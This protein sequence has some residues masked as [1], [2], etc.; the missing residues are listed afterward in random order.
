MPKRKTLGWLGFA[1]AGYWL[2]CDY[3]AK[4]NPRVWL[5]RAIGFGWATVLL[6]LSHIFV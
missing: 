5:P 1:A 2:F 3:Q 6:T 4:S